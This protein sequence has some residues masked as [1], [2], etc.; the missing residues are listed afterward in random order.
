MDSLK[1]PKIKSDYAIIDVTLGR[2]KLESFL[3]KH[4]PQDVIIKA[5]INDAYGGNDGVS[6]MFNADVLEITYAAL[7]S[8]GEG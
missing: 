3:K 2:V 1:P 6:I 7:Q 5:R 4:G 8:D